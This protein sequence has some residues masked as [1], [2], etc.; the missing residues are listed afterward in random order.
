M[1]RLECVAG[2]VGIFA[3]QLGVDPL[4]MAIQSREDREMDEIERLLAE[5]E[6]AVMRNPN[7]GRGGRKADTMRPEAANPQRR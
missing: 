7:T 5:D 3:P 6:E 2:G 1:P 4:G